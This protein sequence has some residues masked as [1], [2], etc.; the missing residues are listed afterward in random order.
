MMGVRRGQIVALVEGV[1]EERHG[2][3]ERRRWN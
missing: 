2:F 3:R 1:E